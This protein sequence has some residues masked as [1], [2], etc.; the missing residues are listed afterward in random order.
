LRT[1]NSSCHTGALRQIAVQRFPANAELFR[2]RS[3]LL[4]PDGPPTKLLDSLRR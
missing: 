3:L 1:C 4:T 2:K